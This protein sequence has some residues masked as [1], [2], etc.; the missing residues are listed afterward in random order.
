MSHISPASPIFLPMHDH[1]EKEVHL[2]LL[3]VPL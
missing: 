1:C 2:I 3:N